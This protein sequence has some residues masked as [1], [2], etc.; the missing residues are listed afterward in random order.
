MA[1]ANTS[2][3]RLTEVSR[4][5]GELADQ[6]L[7]ESLIGVPSPA[8]VSALGEAAIL[9]ED[10]RRPVPDLVT[11]VLTRVHDRPEGDGEGEGGIAGAEAAPP[12]GD[13]GEAAG[14]RSRFI[15]R[16]IRSLRAP[17]A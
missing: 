5:A 2:E 10:Y 16:F 9:L 15:P 3:D 6:V 1:D 13:E 8:K 17:R 4:L 7:L 12:A 14:G 11:D